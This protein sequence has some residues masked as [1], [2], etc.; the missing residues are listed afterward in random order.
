MNEQTLFG[1]EKKKDMVSVLPMQYV[2]FTT[3]GVTFCLDTFN[4]W[5]DGSIKA[6]FNASKVL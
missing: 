6:G 3:E 1:K 4:G 2:N 5:T